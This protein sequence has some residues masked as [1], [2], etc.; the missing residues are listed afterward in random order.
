[1]P[2]PSYSRQPVGESDALAPLSNFERRLLWLNTVLCVLTR[3]FAMSASLWDWDEVLFS[4][5]MLD[6]DVPSHRPHPPGF[7]LFILTAKFARWFISNDFHALQTVN[8]LAAIFLLPVLF[9]LCRE[10]RFP[11]HVS[12]LAANLCVFFPNVWFFGGT[13]FSDV[14]SLTLA[15]LACYLLLRGRR[16]G[17]AYVAG[18]IVLGLAAGY[19]SQNLLLGAAPALVASLVQMRRRKWLLVAVAGTLGAVIVFGSYWGAARA[20]SSPENFRQAIEHH[21]EYIVKVDSF[22]S[23]T[24][25]PLWRLFD[26]FFVRPFRAGVI[27]Y[28]LLGLNLV[29]FVHALLKRYRPVLWAMVIFVPFGI[30]AWLILDIM[31]ISR[32]S[33]GYIPLLAILSADGLTLICAL[34]A[35]RYG[36][37]QQRLFAIAA[38][39]IVLT[40]ILWSVPALWT[41]RSTDSPPAASLRWIRSH[42]KPGEGRIYVASGMLPF[43]QYALSDYPLTEVL[44]DRAV[45]LQTVKGQKAYLLIEGASENPAAI[46]FLRPRR[47][48]WKVVRHRYFEVSII[49]MD[50]AARFREGWYESEN[51]GAEAW[52]WMGR[53]SVTELPPVGGPA[54][55]QLD[56]QFPLDTLLTTPMV[57]VS[58]NGIVLDRF[59]ASESQL[60]RQYLVSGEVNKI[61]RLMIETT[62]AVNPLQRGLADDPRDLGLLLRSISWG[63]ASG[64]ADDG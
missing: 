27:N 51:T 35:R 1:M 9:L 50:R 12:L 28:V 53:R 42:V 45:P 5:A 56:L 4:S 22:L 37:T 49:P 11:Y 15:V 36:V 48:L 59:A 8:L 26:D 13:A 44:D 39:V 30:M 24:R 2:Q 6:Y 62:E 32:F 7:P 34:F 60:K 54:R 14:P 46:R 40:L 47:R 58:L 64:V 25:P 3:W 43:A 20:S 38:G 57:T 18:A 16:D 23:P 63:P 17:W 10:L 29:S 41:A 61:N 55:L 21:R 33:L 19:R 31:S 52:R